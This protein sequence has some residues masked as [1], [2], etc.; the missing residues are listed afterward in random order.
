MVCL[1]DAPRGQLFAS[2]DAGGHVNA[3][4]QSDATADI[5]KHASA[6]DPTNTQ[7]TVTHVSSHVASTKLGW[8]G[9]VRHC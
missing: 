7:T 1:L 9:G 3:P 4:C 8:L 6:H 5:C 2:V